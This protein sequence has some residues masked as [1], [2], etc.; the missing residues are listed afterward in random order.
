MR[1]Q[2]KNGNLE[3]QRKGLIYPNNSRRISKILYSDQKGFLL[4]LK[5]S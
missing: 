2:I 4:T 5:N 1:R 3:I